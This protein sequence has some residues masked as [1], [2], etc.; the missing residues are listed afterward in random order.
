M[1][2]EADILAVITGL[3]SF[4][5]KE[6]VEL[7]QSLNGN[8]MLSK[9]AD[10]IAELKISEFRLGL[11]YRVEN[12]LSGAIIT[13]AE[14]KKQSGEWSSLQQDKIEFLLLNSDFVESHF[15]RYIEEIEGTACCADKS[16]T[17][18]ASLAKYFTKGKEIEFDYS[19]EYTYHLPKLVFTHHSEIVDFFDGLHSFYYGNPERY[20]EVSKDLVEKVR[21]AKQR[22]RDRA[23]Y[24]E[25][26]LAATADI[27]RIDRK[28]L[29]QKI[30]EK[31]GCA[32]IIYDGFDEMKAPGEIM[33]LLA[34]KLGERLFPR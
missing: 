17:I 31:S 33:W 15:R 14:Q 23:T 5:D 25:R 19:G 2:T 28:Q 1:T 20:F 27:M 13:V 11:P 6:S 9:I 8:G 32:Q 10:D 30:N 12:L 4:H 7:F 26:C 18:V 29:V 3:V 34:E 21:E 24:I 16:R 22:E